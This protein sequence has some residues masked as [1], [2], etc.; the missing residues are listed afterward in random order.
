M[1]K[2]EKFG[3]MGVKGFVLGTTVLFGKKQD[4]KEIL[5]NI[6]SL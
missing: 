6:R 3:P 2:I 4:Y 5:S 1:D